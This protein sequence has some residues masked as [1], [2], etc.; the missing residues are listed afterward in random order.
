MKT[1]QQIIEN[2]QAALPHILHGLNEAEKQGT[3]V[4]VIAAQNKD[5]GGQML[6]TINDAKELIE[7]IAILADIPLQLSKEQT[8]EFKARSFL[9][10]FGLG[11]ANGT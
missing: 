7:D 9:A 10:K 1:K 3:P 5:G 8:M 11:N 2:L 4:L 6:L